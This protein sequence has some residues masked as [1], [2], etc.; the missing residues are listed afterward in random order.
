M[1]KKINSILDGFE[2]EFSE[3]TKVFLNDSSVKLRTQGLG[4]LS[5]EEA[6]ELGAV[7]PMARASGI[8]IDMRKSGYAA[9]GKLKIEPVVETAGDCYA[10]TSVRIREVFQSIDLIRQCISLI[11]DGEIKVKIVGN[12]SGEYFTR[13]SSPAEKFILCKANGTKFL[14]RFRV[15]TPTFANIPALLHTLKGCQLADVPVLILTIDPCISC[16]ER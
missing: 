13:W 8:D 6:F 1:L 14:E 12:P 7:G 16:T 4:V 10:R 9:Y 15:R 3:I 5:R 2:K 11:P